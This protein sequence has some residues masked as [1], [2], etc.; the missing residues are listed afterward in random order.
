VTRNGSGST[1]TFTEHVV[2]GNYVPYWLH[3]LARPVFRIFVTRA[4]RQQLRNLARLA[5]E[6]MQ[7]EG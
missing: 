5:E 6:R 2:D 3:P 7:A 1:I 4:D